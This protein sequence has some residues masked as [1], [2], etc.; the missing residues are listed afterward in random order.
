M[1]T[2]RTQSDP[3]PQFKPSGPPT[4]PSQLV[5]HQQCEAHVPCTPLIQPPACMFPSR[6]P[7]VTHPEVEFPEPKDREQSWTCRRHLISKCTWFDGRKSYFL[8]PQYPKG[9]KRGATTQP[10]NPAQR[11][12][13]GT[14]SSQRIV[15]AGPRPK[16][17]RDGKNQ[18][19]VF[20][21]NQ[22][23]T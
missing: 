20:K 18:P 21:F 7:L 9:R 23:T 14:T 8:H 17:A 11:H 22:K 19:K 15:L 5:S 13:L 2:S 3:K 1:P 6:P 12:S 16:L 4:T 10:L